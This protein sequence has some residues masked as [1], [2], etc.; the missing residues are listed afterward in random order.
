[1][2]FILDALRKSEERRQS[3]GL[4]TNG[5]RILSFP[6]GPRSGSSFPWAWLL[7]LL[8]PAALLIGWWLGRTPPANTPATV[9]QTSQETV[10]LAVPDQPAAQESSAPPKAATAPQAAAP[11]QI[12]PQQLVAP[13]PAPPD[14]AT[15]ASKPAPQR[16]IGVAKPAGETLIIDYSELSVATRKRLPKLEMSLHFYSPDPARRIVR[17]NGQLLHEGESLQE[18]PRVRQITATAVILSADGTNFR[19]KSGK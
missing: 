3:A 13:I 1:M 16:Q 15:A 9:P 12:S 14:T 19:I 10:A 6:A 5:S 11:E 18:G 8:L 4:A 17:L 7:L 2:S